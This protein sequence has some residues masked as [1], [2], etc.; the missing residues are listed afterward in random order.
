MNFIEFARGFGLLLDHP[1][2]D[3]RWHRIPTR[4]KP[5]RRNGAYAFWGDAG[6]VQNWAQMERV[7]LWRDSGAVERGGFARSILRADTDIRRRQ[8]MARKASIA[9]LSECDRLPHPYLAC[10]GFPDVLGLVH[11]SGDLLVPM[12]DHRDYTVINSVQRIS[13]DSTKKFLPGGK[14]KGSVFR[15]GSRGP[16]WLVEGYATALSVHAAL[17]DLRQTAQVLVCFSAGNLQYVAPFVQGPA[18]VFAD[19]D[20]S[21]AGEK[22]ALATGLPYCMAGEVGDANDLMRRSG[23]RRVCAL[24]LDAQNSTD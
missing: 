5:A 1:I 15:I 17:Q 13:P 19:H 6:A 4:D 8:E 14:A 12:R 20:E 10:K 18:Y 7:A 24:M 16:T 11:P 2:A 3:G 22:A 9:L 23:L 21:Q